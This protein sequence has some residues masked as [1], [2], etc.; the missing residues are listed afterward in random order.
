MMLQVW[1]GGSEFGIVFPVGASR[2]EDPLGTASHLDRSR[3]SID[4]RTDAG[5]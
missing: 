1:A 5:V 3:H 2:F 4:R